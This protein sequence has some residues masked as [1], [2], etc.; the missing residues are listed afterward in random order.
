MVIIIYNN[1]IGN[2]N[3]ITPL[4]GTA[5]DGGGLTDQ[6]VQKHYTLQ[7]EILRTFQ[8]YTNTP[9]E[10][11]SFSVLSRKSIQDFEIGANYFAEFAFDQSK[12]LVSKR[13]SIHQNTV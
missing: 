7:M 13:V 2:L 4:Y 9:L 6:K 5:F 11:K 10:I 1:F 12:I 3:V 8:L